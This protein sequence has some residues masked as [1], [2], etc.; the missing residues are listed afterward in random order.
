MH[1]CYYAHPIDEYI[2]RERMASYPSGQRD[3]TVNQLAL[4]SGVR[5]PHSPQKQRGSA[6][7][8]ESASTADNPP[9]VIRFIGHVD[10]FDDIDW[11][12]KF[13]DRSLL[14]NGV[15]CVFGGRGEQDVLAVMGYTRYDYPAE[16]RQGGVWAWHT[17]WGMSKPYPGC[18]DLVF[19]HIDRPDERF[20]KQ[21]PALNWWVGKSF[22]ELVAMKPPE[23]SRQM[24]AIASTR[25]HVAGHHTRNAFI[26]R[27]ISEFPDIDVYG[28][29]R[30]KSL[31]NK[32]DG[33]APYKYTIAI[34]NGSTPD[35]WTEKLTDAFMG[36]SVPLYFGAPNIR[37]YFPADSFI[38][39]PIDEP[40]KALDVIRDTLENDSWEDRL[41]AVSQARRAIFDRWGFAA[42]VTQ[43]VVERENE[44]RTA[45][46]VRVRVLGRRMW[47]NGW[48]RDVGVR[49]NLGIHTRF[50][51]RRITKVF[52][53]R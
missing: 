8:D 3:L 48:V 42:Q 1:Y 47:K 20:R 19:T 18:Y 35:Y 9:L 29:G 2:G 37:D 5:I 11:A 13:P 23:K 43:A 6:M 33:I 22:D 51:A 34:E 39:L 50:I 52:R 25:A 10:D 12:A 7:V 15:Q 14:L 27:V 17:E 16:V 30:P 28:H 45:P 41:E 40:E 4:P 53:R 31:E 38:W 46:K 44:L 36:W 21:P 24:S 49:K 32:W 26:E